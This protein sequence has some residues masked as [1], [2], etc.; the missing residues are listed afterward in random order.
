MY[1]YGAENCYD[2]IMLGMMILM[3]NSVIPMMRDGFT[4]PE[5]LEE[6]AEGTC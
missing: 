6:P 2:V 3:M 4:F 5:G 1:R